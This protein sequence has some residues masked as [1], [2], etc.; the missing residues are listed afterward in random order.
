MGIIA[1]ALLKYHSKWTVRHWRKD[2]GGIYRLIWED[3]AI[4]RNILHDTGEQAILSAFFATTMANFGAPPANLYL[5]LDKHTPLAEADT[6]ATLDEIASAGYERKAC[7]S[8]GTGAAGQDFV[9]AQAAAYYAATSKTVTWTAG[10]NWSAALKSI[11]LCT[12]SV[13]VVD[14]DGDHLISSLALSAERTLLNA[15]KLEGSMVTGLSE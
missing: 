4:D 10:E 8:A 15:D 12:D 11:F 14:G 5:G 13:A 2:K 7:S 9:I 1:K 6:L 3:I